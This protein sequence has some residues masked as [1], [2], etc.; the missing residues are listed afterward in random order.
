MI[1]YQ[2][3]KNIIFLALI[4]HLVGCFAFYLDT[5]AYNS[6]QYDGDPSDFW[7]LT[8]DAYSNIVGQDLWVRYVYCFYFSASLVSGVAYGDLI[9]QNPISTA[10]VFFILFLPIVIYSYIFSVVYSVFA[11]KR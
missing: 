4:N 1:F 3:A 7:I 2:L 5:W 8:S 11:K 9:P 10:Y 6:N